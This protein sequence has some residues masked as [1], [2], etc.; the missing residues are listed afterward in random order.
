MLAEKTKID[1]R[2]FLHPKVSYQYAANGVI[3][4]V[5]V[6][7][8]GN[9][10]CHDGLSL[11][12]QASESSYCEPRRNLQE[13]EDPTVYTHFEIALFHNGDFCN[14]AKQTLLVNGE[15]FPEEVSSCSTFADC[16]RIRA[17]KE[18]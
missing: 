7:A 11:S 9:F 8:S 1:F 13:Y 12:V 10:T 4:G 2:C 14:P 15:P 3:C 18:L 16:T 6:G 17:C 5:E